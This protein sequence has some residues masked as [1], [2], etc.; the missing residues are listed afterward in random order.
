MVLATV[1]TVVVVVVIAGGVTAWRLTWL[2]PA[3]WP[4]DVAVNEQTDA[5][6]DRVEYRLA[7]EAHKVRPDTAPWRLRVREDHVNAWLTSRLPQWLAHS[8]NVEWP[9]SL[10]TPRVRFVQGG[11]SIGLAFDDH[12]RRRYVVADLEPQ[13]LDGRLSLTLNGVSLGRLWVPGGSVQSLIERYRDVVPEGF[14]DDPA[15]RRVIDML[16]NEQRFEPS[17]DLTDGRQ[18][19]LVDL[20]AGDGEMIIECETTRR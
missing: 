18:V 7:E 12:G 3:W 10:G 5:L 11:V 20:V 2:E 15:V 13:I 14:I 9:S 16:A 4:E 8:E 6:A 19:R 1:A 17:F